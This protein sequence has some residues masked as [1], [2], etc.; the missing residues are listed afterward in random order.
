M[1]N[2]HFSSSVELFPCNTSQRGNHSISE[3]QVRQPPEGS[4]G[5]HSEASVFLTTPPLTGA[6]PTL[7]GLVDPGSQSHMSQPLVW[8]LSPCTQMLSHLAWEPGPGTKI[9]T[10]SVCRS[11]PEGLYVRE[12]NLAFSMI[13]IIHAHYN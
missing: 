2:T 12:Y 3:N 9:I 10:C 8:S 7:A 6:W 5:P 13:K 1:L 4:D 11:T